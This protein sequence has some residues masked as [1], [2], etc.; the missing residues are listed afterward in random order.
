MSK[1]GLYQLLASIALGMTYLV[2]A[3]ASDN[4]GSRSYCVG[5]TSFPRWFDEGCQEALV[6]RLLIIGLGAIPVVLLLYFAGKTPASATAKHEVLLDPRDN[7]YWCKNCNF[8]SYDVRDA[9]THRGSIF[10]PAKAGFRPST[11]STNGRKA[12]PSA[13]RHVF[14]FRGGRF[15]CSAPGCAFSAST[16]EAFKDHEAA[17]RPATGG[18]RVEGATA[19]HIGAEPTNDFGF[20][21]ANRSVPPTPPVSATPF[22]P[23]FK[24]CPDCAEEIRFA[25]R[26]CRFCGYLYEDAPTEA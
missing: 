10:D 5:L 24:T 14:A 16:K 20:G 26:K 17:A 19:A 11:P 15:V 7:M 21:P 18:A 8:W 4:I 25:A 12:Q 22:A 6:P 23:E 3:G 9:R 2:A 1:R 13:E